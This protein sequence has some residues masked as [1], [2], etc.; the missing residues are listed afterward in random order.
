MG[1][2]KSEK[3]DFFMKCNITETGSWILKMNRTK[4]VLNCKAARPSGD[5][6][7]TTVLNC[8]ALI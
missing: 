5:E 3:R 1:R 4:K 8:K 6:T 2:K 7:I